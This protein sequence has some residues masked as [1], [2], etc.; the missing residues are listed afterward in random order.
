MIFHWIKYSDFA[1]TFAFLSSSYC[2][3]S[4]FFSSLGWTNNLWNWTHSIESFFLFWSIFFV[5][6]KGREKKVIKKQQQ[7][8]WEAFKIMQIFSLYAFLSCIIFN[9]TLQVSL[10][11]GIMDHG[12]DE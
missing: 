2:L 10:L 4:S 6:K 12:W 8:A 11:F 3:F 5:D 7:T 1:V 9:Y